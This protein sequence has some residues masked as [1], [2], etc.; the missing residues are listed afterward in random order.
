MVEFPGPSEAANFT[1]ANWG[2]L[3]VTRVS[4]MPKPAKTVCFKFLDNRSC[5]H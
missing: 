1:E 3:S 4:G 2:P 5:R